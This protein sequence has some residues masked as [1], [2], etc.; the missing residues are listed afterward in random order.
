MHDNLEAKL[1]FVNEIRKECD[2]TNHRNIQLE[3]NPTYLEQNKKY[4]EKIGTW[5]HIGRTTKKF[6]TYKNWKKLFGL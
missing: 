4:K 6:L 2:N 3:I 1:M 5:T